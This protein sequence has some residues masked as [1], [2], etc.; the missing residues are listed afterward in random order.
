MNKKRLLIVGGLTFLLALTTLLLW[1]QSTGAFDVRIIRLHKDTINGGKTIY[2]EP[3]TSWI[4]KDT[5]VIWVNQARPDEVK[6]MFEDGKQ[7]A[8][9]TSSATA[10]NLEASCFVTSW[11]PSGG[12]SSL[13]FNEAGIFEYIV[14]ASDGVKAKGKIV[15]SQERY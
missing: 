4:P 8:D 5:V 7:C 10:F 6:I 3:N 1:H 2:I 13:K 14:E 9:V 15:V 11:I 12:T